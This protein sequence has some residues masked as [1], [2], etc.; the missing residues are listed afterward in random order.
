[1]IYRKNTGER[2][3]MYNENVILWIK[4]KKEIIFYIDRQVIRG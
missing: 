4:F 1:M 3:K 2:Q